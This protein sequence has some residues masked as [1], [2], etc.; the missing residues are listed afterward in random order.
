ML[1][2]YWKKDFSKLPNALQARVS[3]WVVDWGNLKERQNYA[4]KIDYNNDPVLAGK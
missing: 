1:A 3:T 2:D 4:L